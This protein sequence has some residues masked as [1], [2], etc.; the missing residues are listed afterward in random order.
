[1]LGR[2]LLETFDVFAKSRPFQEYKVVGWDLDEIDIRQESLTISRIEG[3]AP[4]IILHLAAYTDVDAC[5]TNRDEA[6]QVNAE[7]TKHV[8]RGAEA[9][10]AKVVYL[11]TDY[12]FDGK[13]TEPYLESD[14]PHPL[15]VYGRSKLKGEEYLQK[16]LDDY[17]IVRTQWLY[18]RHGKNFVDSILRQSKEKPVLSIVNDQTGSPTYTVD[19][20]KGII[21]LVGH[22]SRGIFHVTNG[23]VCTWYDFGR[24]ILRFSEIEGVKVVPISSQAL[25]RAAPRPCYSAL[26]SRK[27]REETGLTLR[28]WSEA[29]KEY[30]SHPP[31]AQKKGRE[32]A[33]KKE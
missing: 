2:D 28:H 15:N 8:V 31:F 13:K 3:L 23:D 26:D 18:G 32:E 20:S 33:L 4:K 24:A 17:L 21:A 19:L 5:E 6:F 12:V 14:A 9:C 11:S 30:L 1:M 10:G 16:G 27:L 7:G 29:L 25:G 22:E